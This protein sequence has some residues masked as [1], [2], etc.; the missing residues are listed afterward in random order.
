MVDGVK[1][2]GALQALQKLD[3]KSRATRIQQAAQEV[4][5]RA[6]DEVQISNEGRE[7]A[8]AQQATAQVKRILSDLS[9][10]TLGLHSDFAGE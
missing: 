1:E 4:V 8:E 7:L 9:T 3:M 10:V 5:S 2:S 6:S